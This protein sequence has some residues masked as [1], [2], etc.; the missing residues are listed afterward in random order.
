MN[1]SP[2]LIAQIDLG[3]QLDIIGNAA[4]GFGHHA[5]E[6]LLGDRGRENQH[7]VGHA[8]I[9]L[10]VL[11]NMLLIRFAD[12]RARSSKLASISKGLMDRNEDAF[13]RLAKP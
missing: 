6:E 11:G 3:H 4:S 9:R 12:D 1:E 13:E 5:G 2:S 7:R 8:L 10:P